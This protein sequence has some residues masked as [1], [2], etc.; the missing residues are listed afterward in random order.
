MTRDSRFESQFAD[1]AFR[2]AELERRARNR[3]RT[4]TV[5]AVDH[6]GGRAR[7]EFSAPGGRPYLGPWMPWKEIA[8]GR[9]RSHIPPSVGEQVDVVS[10]SGD[11]ADGVIDMSIPSDANPRPHDGPEAVITKGA[12]RVQ[13]G[14]D[15]AEIITPTLRIKADVEI[16]GTVAITGA[17]ITHDGHE[18]GATHLHTGVIPGGGISG[19][20]E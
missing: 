12:T 20:P 7:V 1:L 4:G 2:I 16:E 18:I 17:S 6:A 3:K 9:I 10:E 15:T 11:L 8:A 14:D 5:V 13:I 19:P